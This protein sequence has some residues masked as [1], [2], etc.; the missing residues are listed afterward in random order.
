MATLGLSPLSTGIPFVYYVYTLLGPYYRGA[1]GVKQGYKGKKL[2]S[3]RGRGL[4]PLVTL[5][6]N[7]SKIWL[8]VVYK[9]YPNIRIK[10]K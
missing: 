5:Q 3:K 2:G 7:P 9:W 4:F 1:Q 10:S 6:K 8:I